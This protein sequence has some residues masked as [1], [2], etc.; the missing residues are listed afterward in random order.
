MLDLRIATC[1]ELCGALGMQGLGCS[2][3]PG[4]PCGALHLAN[5]IATLADVTPFTLDCTPTGCTNWIW[6]ASSTKTMWYLN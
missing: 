4:A 2:P 5:S 1:N 6:P 3:S